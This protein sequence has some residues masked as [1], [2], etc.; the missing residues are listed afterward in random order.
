M[1][2]GAIAGAIAGKLIGKSTK[3]TVIGGAAGAAAGAATAAATANYQGCIQS[4]GSIVVKLNSAATV[5]V[6]A[7][8]WKSRGHPA[9]WLGM[10]YCDLAAVAPDSHSP[11]GR[12]RS[13]IAFNRQPR[14]ESR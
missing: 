10:T 3:A 12:A 1:G 11:A 13:A 9:L 14:A 7:R 4:G 6:Q 2:I 5:R 8:R